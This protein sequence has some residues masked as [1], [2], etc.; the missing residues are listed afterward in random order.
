MD[1]KVAPA[2][3]ANSGKMESRPRVLPGFKCCRAAVNAFCEKFSEIFTESGVI[4]LRS[5][6]TSC[7][8][9]WSNKDSFC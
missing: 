4:T 3:I 9:E 7:Q 2:W 8:D 1:F 6:D 5:S